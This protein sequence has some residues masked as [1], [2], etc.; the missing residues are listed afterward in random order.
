M[1]RESP[2]GNS[3]QFFQALQVLGMVC[4]L[5]F[6]SVSISN[7]TGTDFDYNRRFR[8][9]QQIH[10][11]VSI[12]G[13]GVV[14]EDGVVRYP[15][16]KNDNSIKWNPFLLGTIGFHTLDGTAF[17]GLTG[18]LGGYK[19]TYGFGL[20]GSY[21]VG[22][23]DILGYDVTMQILNISASFSYKLGNSTVILSSGATFGF[24]SIESL[25]IGRE[26]SGRTT[27]ITY[28]YQPNNKFT[29]MVQGRI[30]GKGIMFSA[31]VGF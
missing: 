11:D 24:F 12:P 15:Q 7:A 4:L 31:G 21:E 20:L 9:G 29:L 30:Q 16:S 5:G 13:G 2:K 25:D 6:S 27:S 14:G 22:G 23:T 18:Y 26:D 1:I 17:G 8:V 19:T 10:S 28:L 3:M